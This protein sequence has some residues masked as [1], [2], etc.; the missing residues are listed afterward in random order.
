M[1]DSSL[2]RALVDTNIVIYAHDPTDLVKHEMAQ[3][4]LETLSDAGCLTYSAQ[5][6]NEFCSNMI[7]S[8][9]Q[10]HGVLL[11]NPDDPEFAEHIDNFRD[12]YEWMREQMAQRISGYAG[13]VGDSF[14]G[15]GPLAFKC[16]F[17]VSL[18]ATRLSALISFPAMPSVAVLLM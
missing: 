6:F 8:S 16:L 11:V 2:E 3:Q 14:G 7:R 5:V 12:A 17:W 18:S 13:S 10:E 9:L 15:V 4:L 1:S